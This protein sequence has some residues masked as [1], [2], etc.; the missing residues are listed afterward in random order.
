[1]RRRLWLLAVC[2]ASVAA[3]VGGVST[4][5]AQTGTIRCESRGSARDQCAIDRGAQVR[6]VRQLSSQ[7]CRENS[8]WGVGSGYIWVYGGCRA[9]FAVSAI[10]AY[11]PG[12]G[13]ANATPMQLRAC[14]S[15]ADRRTPEYGYDQI[16]VEAYQREG[17]TAWI[18]WSA[19]NTGGSCTVA[20]S[21]RILEF[22]T[23]TYGEAG[24][25]GA[26]RITCE[27]KGTARQ[28]C[29]IP[30]GSQIRLLRQLSQNPCRI[31][32]TYGRGQ[33]YVWVAEGCRAEFEIV[34]AGYPGGPGGPGG[35]GGTMQVTCGSSGLNR[36]TCPIPPG[37]TARLVRQLSQ[38]S[39]R[40]NATYGFERDA[41]W[42]ANGCRGQ[43]EVTRYGT[44]GG[45]P[46]GNVTR[47][48]CSSSGTARQ[49]CGVPGA[50]R[51][52]LVRQISTSPC[53]LNQS[54]GIGIDH[55]WVSNGCRGEFDVMVGGPGSGTVP[56]L[57][58]P[59]ER[60]TCESRGSDRVECRVREGA[61]VELSRQLSS[62]PCIRNRTWGAGYG[63]IWVQQGCRGEYE[64]R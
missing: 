28:E 10:G 63:R 45:G 7:P 40:L 57:P 19:G 1:M 3:A 9:E 46:G 50:S 58:Q 51:V 16:E 14:R 11:P 25:P 54:Y 27:S 37:S 13:Y 23:D 60:V 20:S 47:I 43:F 4:A 36:Q 53:T 39:C 18:R 15:E 21:G 55:I 64:V 42:V 5:A 32:D 26:T 34:R 59:A 24:G 33:G 8:T 12:G 38:N 48:T 61:S 41:I 62:A 2:G 56:G 29:P 44:P 49:Q 35:G 22:T 30:S 17:S 52:T 6:L 31:N